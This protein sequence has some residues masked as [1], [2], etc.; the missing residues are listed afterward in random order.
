[1]G[2]LDVAWLRGRVATHSFKVP[3]IQD[4][5]LPV[6]PI[7]AAPD[8]KQFFVLPHFAA[9]E[10]TTSSEARNP[11]LLTYREIREIS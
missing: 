9:S 10:S 4:F 1:M 7:N 11:V 3:E 2:G 6:S 5:D 8:D